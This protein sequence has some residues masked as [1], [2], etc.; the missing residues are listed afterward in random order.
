M[1]EN[2]DGLLS[3]LGVDP[4]AG[5]PEASA[6]TQT[7]NVDTSTDSSNAVETPATDTDV[8]NNAANTGDED[9][10]AAELNEEVDAQAQ[11]EQ[12]RANQ[13]FAAMRAENSK[14]KKFM[15]TLM[16]GSNF[17]GNEEAFIKLLEDE[18]YKKQ[19]QIQGMAANPELLRKM[20]QQEEQIKELTQAQRDQT[21]ML[22]L[23]TLQQTHGLTGKEVEAFV[24]KAIENRIDLLAPG[25][26]FDTLY[27]GMFFDDIMKKK[28]ESE[29][30]NWI[31]QSNKA[32]SAANPDGKSG[33]KETAPT[34]VKTMA[35][36]NSLLNTVSKEIK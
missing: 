5:A 4:N 17:A 8:D 6:D 22:G 29:R 1:P 27:K 7:D 20:D 16:R 25:T 34:D 19:A 23:K 35:E 15:Q 9:D 13:A 26:N 2:I 31:K 30:Q 18:A 11:L 21:L 32:D 33:R 36:F 12:Q 24:Q 10:V 28:V 3:D 14:Y